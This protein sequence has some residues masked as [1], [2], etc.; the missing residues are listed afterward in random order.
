MIKYYEQTKSKYSR[1]IDHL[2]TINKNGLWIKENLKPGHRIIS[3][4]E[5]KKSILKNVTI[6][7]LNE[8]Y[9]LIEKINSTSA[10]I[11]TN[12]WVLSDVRV[13]KFESIWL[14]FRI[15]IYHFLKN[16][17][18]FILN[19][20]LTYYRQL[21]NSAS[22]NFKTLS[23]NWWFRRAQAHEIVDFF[24]VKLNQNKKMNIDKLIT[25]LVLFF[26]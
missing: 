14:D 1:D 24:S 20:N 25:K 13:N 12:N 4:D 11:S 15:A 17:D 21:D 23:K 18:L 5:T 6:F 7:N 3:A 19:K 22:K 10:D 9:E 2:V 26:L 8:D 16:K